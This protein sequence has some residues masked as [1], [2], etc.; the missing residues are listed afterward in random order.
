MAGLQL[1]GQHLLELFDRHR[2]PEQVSLADRTS[3]A[4]Q[5]LPLCSGIHSFYNRFHVKFSGQ[6]DDGL[7]D[8]AVVGLN[9]NVAY[10]TLVSFELVQW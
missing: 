9:A 10:E 4:Q 1:L 7:K 2:A 5:E 6:T 8:D 3:V